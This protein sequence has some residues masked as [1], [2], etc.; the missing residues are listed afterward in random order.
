[1]KKLITLLFLILFCSTLAGF[2]GATTI[3]VIGG[4]GTICDLTDSSLAKGNA[5]RMDVNR[6]LIEAE[7]WL[8]FNDTQTLGFYV[9]E[10]ATEFGTYSEIYSNSNSVT[11][12]GEGWFSSGPLSVSLLDYYFYII[13]TSWSG[14]TIYYFNVADTEATS[15]GAYVHGYT[16]GSHPL[17]GTISSNVNDQAVYYQRLTTTA[18]VPE[19][20]TMFLLGFG[21]IGLAGFRRKFKK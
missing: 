19:P 16:T 6:T 9:Y 15:F 13:A 10:S 17:G 8:N 12:G 1:M 20:A 3:D 21:L 14:N 4:T 18:S 5:Y 11:G 2:A 7:F